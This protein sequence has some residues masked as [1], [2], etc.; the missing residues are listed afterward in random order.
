MALV[1]SVDA[2]V[3]W[4]TCATEDPVGRDCPISVTCAQV[5]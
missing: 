3:H 1:T 4:E 2:G 5:K